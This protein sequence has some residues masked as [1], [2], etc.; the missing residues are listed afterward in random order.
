MK[1]L[2]AVYNA[3]THLEQNYKRSKKT[4]KEYIL[5]KFGGDI[6]VGSLV[7]LDYFAGAKLDDPDDIEKF[8][9]IRDI[10]S[11]IK[12]SSANLDTLSSFDEL[13]TG[14]NQ[15][16]KVLLEDAAIK[17][18]GI[19]TIPQAPSNEW[20]HYKAT[21]KNVMVVPLVTAKKVRVF[22]DSMRV[23]VQ[24]L[25]G[26]SQRVSVG[27]TYIKDTQGLFILEKH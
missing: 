16:V 10:F 18:S 4:R 6:E 14:G 22:N 1:Q 5:D 2:D 8:S 26:T 12:K 21:A 7:I 13:L 23:F 20:A 3:F 11:A 27:Q 24:S 25:V 17:G 19:L 15:A 9:T